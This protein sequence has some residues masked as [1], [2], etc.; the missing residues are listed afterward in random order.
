M[1]SCRPTAVRDCLLPRVPEVRHDAVRI[2]LAKFHSCFLQ[3]LR[4]DQKFKD[5][6]LRLKGRKRSRTN[7]GEGKNKDRNEIESRRET[8]AAAAAAAEAAAA[9][10]EQVLEPTC[11]PLGQREDRERK[12]E[13]G[14]E[15]RMRQDRAKQTRMRK[16][17][18]RGQQGNEE[19]NGRRSK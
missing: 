2:G 12:G 18:R 7:R 6:P 10:T 16:G 8:A 19:V 5:P 4:E 14:K 11:T 1:S 17:G 15:M 9:C 3:I 13:T